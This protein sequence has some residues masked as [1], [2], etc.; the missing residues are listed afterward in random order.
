MHC[1]VVRESEKDKIIDLMNRGA[2]VGII[3]DEKRKSH[4]VYKGVFIVC[5]GNI[6]DGFA[7]YGPFEN[8]KG[9]NK[10]AVDN[11]MSDLWTIESMFMVKQDD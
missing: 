7:F 9:A 3:M 6:H 5:D 1:H 11:L 4:K 8:S 2:G 10:W